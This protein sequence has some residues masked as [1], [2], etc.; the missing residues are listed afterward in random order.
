MPAMRFTNNNEH[1]LTNEPIGFP[2]RK[3]LKTEIVRGILHSSGMMSKPVLMQ[4]RTIKTFM[5]D[6]KA[7]FVASAAALGKLLPHFTQIAASSQAEFP[8]F[9]Q[10]F[11]L[12][13]SSYKI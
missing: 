6:A 1:I 13:D 11:I 8:H 5:I 10:Y 9:S 2:L 4:P 12:S 3:L 7:L